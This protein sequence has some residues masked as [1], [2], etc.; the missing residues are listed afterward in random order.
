MSNLPRATSNT[1][2]T[3]RAVSPVI[4]VALLLGIT[5]VLASAI[6]L[7]VLGIGDSFSEN[8]NANVEIAPGSGTNLDLTLADN[9]NVDRVVIVAAENGY[10]NSATYPDGSGSGSATI[11]S[12]TG[13]TIQAPN[14]NTGSNLETYQVVGVIEQEGDNNVAVLDEFEANDGALGSA[15]HQGVSS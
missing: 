9:G 8:P 11:L 4:G 2:S 3:D 6:G 14:G 10:S 7:S 12:N 13:A 15:S 1:D 5:V